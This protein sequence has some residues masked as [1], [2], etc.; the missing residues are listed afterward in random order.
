MM[1]EPVIRERVVSKTREVRIHDA[2]AVAATVGAFADAV[3]QPERVVVEIVV[4][5]IVEDA[6]RM[7]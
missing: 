1:K 6:A 3:R 4:A 5:N 7:C 2:I